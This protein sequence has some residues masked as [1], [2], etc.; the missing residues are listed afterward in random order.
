MR[1][2]EI[3]VNRITNIHTQYVHFSFSDDI[4]KP[5]TYNSCVVQN[6]RRN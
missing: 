2:V 6:N 3:C 5:K 1:Q 4:V